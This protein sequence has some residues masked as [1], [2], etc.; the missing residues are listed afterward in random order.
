MAY[1]TYDIS[2]ILIVIKE[3]IAILLNC[4]RKIN[5]T[6]PSAINKTLDFFRT[7]SILPVN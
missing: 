6:E 2:F 7:H 1:V 4:F 5:K 3:T